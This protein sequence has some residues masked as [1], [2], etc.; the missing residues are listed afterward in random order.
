MVDQSWKTAWARAAAIL[1]LC[2]GLAVVI[3][4]AG[5]A[6]TGNHEPHTPAA[7]PT[8]APT[9]PT[10]TTTVASTP[11]QDAGFI[12][13]LN[14]KGIEFRNPDVAVVNGKTVCQ[15]LAAGMTVQ[16]VA[17]QFRIA[18]EP[19]FGVHAED[20]VGVSVRTYCPRYDNPVT[21]P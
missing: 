10:A 9:P 7:A 13:A 16:Q 12:D 8:S 3:V 19:E 18:N 15:N 5:L 4:A 2:L 21:G 20:F 14:K 6:L 17:T 1:L 11:E